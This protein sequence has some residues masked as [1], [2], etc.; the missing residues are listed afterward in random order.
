[1]FNLESN[2]AW[3]L[4]LRDS[5][6]K[7]GREASNAPHASDAYRATWAVWRK[8]LEECDDGLL[9]GVPVS[10][11]NGDRRFRGFTLKEISQH[12]WVKAGR[13]EDNHAYV[14]TVRRF[15]AVQNGDTRCID[16]WTENGGNTVTGSDD[17]LSL[18][19]AEAP[20][21]VIAEIHRQNARLGRPPPEV[22]GGTDDV[23]KA[24]RVL[25]AAVVFVIAVWDPVRNVVAYFI[26]LGF[27]FGAY[28]AVLGWNRYPAL[29]AHVAR[30]F[31]AVATLYYYDDFFTGAAGYEIRYRGGRIVASPQLDL[32]RLVGPNGTGLGFSVPKHISLREVFK[33][34]GVENDW[35]LS[36]TSGV[37]LVGVAD[38]RKDSI[39][40]MSEAIRASGFLS[41]AGAQS[42][43]GKAR[44]VMCPIFGRVGVAALQ[45][46][47]QVA[48]RPQKRLF[49]GKFSEGM[50]AFSTELVE[51]L[52]FVETVSRHLPKVEFPLMPVTGTPRIVLTDASYSS[53]RQFIGIFVAVLRRSGPPQYHYS[54]GDIPQWILECA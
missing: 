24:F 48:K 38:S 3:N 25:P 49:S 18:V 13:A 29:I 4:R 9:I 30:R 35:R 26:V 36:H 52:N 8:T 42:F 31:L 10:S 19:G 16:N 43:Y 6:A 23:R 32:G 45:P 22:K 39:R 54:W 50:V 34:L 27:I 47:I 21:H 14:R 33:F 20:S 12:P 1:M 53:K 2:H 11:E 40:D 28:S 44:F 41:K 46:I 7:R 37:A 51:C 5:V 17:K 15:G